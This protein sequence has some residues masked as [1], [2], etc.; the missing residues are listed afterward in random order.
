MSDVK[1]IGGLAAAIT[2]GKVGA[3]VINKYAVP[4]V[5]HACRRLKEKVT[6]KR[7]V[8]GVFENA[9]EMFNDLAG[10]IAEDTE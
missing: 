8:A 9:A 1:S 2:V 6:G 5:A 7:G 10:R 4:P 3:H